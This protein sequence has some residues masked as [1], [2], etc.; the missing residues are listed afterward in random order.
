M[1]YFGPRYLHA[2]L[3][4]QLSL[5]AKLILY[6]AVQTGTERGVWVQEYSAC[7]CVKY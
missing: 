5:V 3:P 7:M 4:G 6:L 1:N 2:A